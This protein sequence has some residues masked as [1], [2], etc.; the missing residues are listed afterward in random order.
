[1]GISTI[2]VGV[3]G[4]GFGAQVCI[5]G[6]QACPDTEVI[7]VC[8]HT[9]AKAEAVAAQY[10]IP[11]AFDDY[12]TMLQ[13]DGLDAVDVTTPPYLHRQMVVAAL[14]AGKHVLCEKPMALAV[15]EAAE[16][17]RTARD[18]RLVGM[19]DHEYRFLPPW[20]YMKKL[21]QDGYLGQ[22]YTVDLTA[23]TSAWA[24]P[25]R[26]PAWAAPD[27][28]PWNW[29]A[30][31][32]KGGGILGALGSHLIDGL[33]WFF[34]DIESVCGQLGPFVGHRRHLPSGEMRAVSADDSFAFLLRFAGGGQGAVR[35]S[36][37]VW[38]GSGIQLKA[39]GSDGTLMLE[40]LLHPAG[41]LLGARQGEN[42]LA[43]L[44]I[45]G[46]FQ[47]DMEYEDRRLGPFIGLVKTMVEGIRTGSEVSPS[48]ADGLK[49]QKV[50]DALGRSDEAGQWVQVV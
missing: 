30:Q 47:F 29:L 5:P 6:F 2:S 15:D 20:A 42:Q 45:P 7:A 49:V 32:E 21:I 31:K 19:I 34:G 17:H 24:D 3:V 28:S 50:M 38:G 33:H 37:V 10:Q 43:E 27:Q 39:Y 46:E 9:R 26:P 1:M 12:D 41:K 14:R 25:E 35:V 48:F 16:M 13:L 44:P 22:L 36:F 4:L 23:Y 18:N 8:S 11:N 40:N